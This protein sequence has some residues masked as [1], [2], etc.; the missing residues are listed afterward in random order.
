MKRGRKTE[1]RRKDHSKSIGIVII[2]VIELIVFLSGYMLGSF[3]NKKEVPV[4]KPE[5]VVNNEV[6]VIE[7][8]IKSFSV[9]DDII[10]E[11]SLDDMIYQ[12]LF[13]TPEAI[14]GVET[15]T[16]AGDSTKN[17][18]KDYPV[19][20]IIY[21]EKNYES[22]DQFS[23]MIRNSQSYSKTPLFIGADKNFEENK[24]LGFNIDL[25]KE[26]IPDY[27][28]AYLN[29]DDGYS[30]SD[31]TLDELKSEGI[32]KDAEF[33]MISHMNLPNATTKNVPSSVSK[34]I[35]TDLIKNELGYKGIIIT[36]S[37][38]KAAITDEYSADEAAVNA[39]KAGVD[40][41]LMPEDLEKAHSALK[42]AV[43]SGEISKEQIEESVRK[44]LSLKNEKGMI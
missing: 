9:V 18:L 29:S 36:D 8:E 30:E 15:A 14:T 10:N 39:V 7:E 12:M 1:T 24:E 4:Q 25:H 27:K 31:K 17:A 3:T 22:D 42:D 33:I 32:S 11:M 38:S 6:P 35:V 26:I 43:E 19:G 23:E 16:R 5:E 13:V 44:I 37:F 20:G 28:N 41:I 2:A 40:I 21:F 34:E